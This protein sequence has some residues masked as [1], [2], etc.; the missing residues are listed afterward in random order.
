MSIKYIEGDM[1]GP[2]LADTDHG[3]IILPHVCNDR[4]AWGA[5]FVVPLGRNFPQ[6]RQSYLAWEDN[7]L[8]QDLKFPVFGLGETQFVNIDDKIFVAN[9]V[10]QTLG[11]VRPLFYNHLARCMDAVANFV[12][13]RNDA[14]EH[15]ARIVCPAFGSGLAGG[16]W[17]FIEQLIHDSW[18]KQGIQVTVYYLA[19][20]LPDVESRPKSS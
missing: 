1:F 20:T 18:I 6:A 12:K 3:P 10:A 15:A 4:G 5:G 14:R 11:G 8:R 17:L 13:E 19:G 16:N 7:K 2:I 9:M